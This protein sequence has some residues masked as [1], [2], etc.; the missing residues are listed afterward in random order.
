MLFSINFLLAQH[1]QQDPN[2]EP[3]FEDSFTVFNQNRWCKEEG[4]RE[5]GKVTED[6]AN[7]LASNAFIN[8]G[9]LVLR[10]KRDTVYHGGNC[11]YME[12]NNGYHFYSSASV[13]S[14]NLYGHGYFEIYAK[15]PVS[16]GYWPAFW[17]WKDN[18]A[19]QSSWYNEIDVFEGKGCYPDSIYTNVHWNFDCPISWNA[20]NDTNRSF[21]GL[22]ISEYHWYGIEWDSSRIYWYI[23]RD[24]VRTERNNWGG[25]GVQHPMHIILSV[26]LTPDSFSDNRINNSTIFPNYMYIDQANVYRLICD[27]EEPIDEIY[28]FV[29]YQYGVKKH[30]SLTG[31]THLPQN[32]NVCLRARDFI[33]LGNGFE[34]PIGTEFYAD[35]NPCYSS[36]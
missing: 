25:E 33:E 36:N 9:K 19:N 7:L 3:V 13:S 30:I 10:V 15:L 21:S 28:D 34:V 1:P 35:V 23:D 11:Y 14:R 8:H 5:A 17:L 18:S 29:N 16:S 24:I 22:N 31:L 6:V 27:C 26:G 4:I 32:G 20:L 12:Q 2:W